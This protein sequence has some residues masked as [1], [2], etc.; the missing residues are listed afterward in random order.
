MSYPFSYTLKTHPRSKHISIRIVQGGEVV[1]TKSKRISVAQVEAVIHKK[2][3]WIISKI[4]LMQ[5]RPKEP[6]MS[7]AEYVELKKKAYEVVTKKVIYFNTLYNFSY[8]KITIKNQKTRWGSCS[9]RGNLNFNYRLATLPEHLV[10]Y[11]VVHELCHL[12]EM[13]HSQR[14]WDLVAKTIPEYKACH[15][16]LR[17]KGLQIS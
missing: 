11:I 6:V 1:V 5:S 10:D 2:R 3:D 8:N 17:E 14:F 16:A 4:K 15:R 12:K 7:R 13:N 9:S